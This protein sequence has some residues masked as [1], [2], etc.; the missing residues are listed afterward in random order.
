MS[1]QSERLE[2]YIRA[3]SPRVSAPE[4]ED[5]LLDAQFAA[6]VEQVDKYAERWWS[7]NREP[8]HGRLARSEGLGARLQSETGAVTTRSV[9]RGDS[10][11]D[12]PRS[13]WQRGVL[14]DFRTPMDQDATAHPLC[15]LTLG[16]PGSG[17]SSVLRRVVA[18]YAR[19]HDCALRSLVC[20]PDVLRER[21]PE[22][23]RGLGS[24]IVQDELSRLC[25]D[26]PADQLGSVGPS[27]LKGALVSSGAAGVLVLD[28]VGNVEHTPRI[29]VDANRR[30]CRV[31]ILVSDLPVTQAVRRAKLRA[32]NAGRLV[33]PVYIERSSGRPMRALRACVDT[34]AVDGYA[35]IDTSGSRGTVPE[36]T[37]SDAQQTFGSTGGRVEYW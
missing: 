27:L 29:V 3:M 35:V 13:D 6:Y 26:D 22:Y 31:H 8:Q 2:L 20:D 32:L 18:S 16:L 12:G 33:E 9:Y 25:Y 11:W 36:L 10:G 5:A 19:H 23:E 15:F 21:F 17:K 14:S 37:E 7:L 34:G 4:S 24:Q 28:M 30:G 1:Y